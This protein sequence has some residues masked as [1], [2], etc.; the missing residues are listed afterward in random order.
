M[1]RVDVLKGSPYL[2]VIRSQSDKTLK[3]LLGTLALGD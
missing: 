1:F 3:S 2:F